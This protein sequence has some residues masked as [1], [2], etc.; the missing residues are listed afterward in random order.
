VLSPKWRAGI[1]AVLLTP[2][3]RSFSDLETSDHQIG[4][5]ANPRRARRQVEPDGSSL[6]GPAHDSCSRALGHKSFYRDRLRQIARL[7]YVGPQSERGMVRDKLQR[8]G[9]N[10]RCR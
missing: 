1:L 7:V 8:N 5:G 2:G 10:K 6:A 3:V 9:K 4:Q